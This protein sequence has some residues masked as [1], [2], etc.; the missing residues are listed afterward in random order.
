MEIP[1]A[2]NQTTP[3]IS[4]LVDSLEERQEV[5]VRRGIFEFHVL[6]VRDPGPVLHL[7]GDVALLSVHRVDQLLL[8]LLRAVLELGRRPA[9]EDS[10]EVGV[11][12]QADPVLALVQDASVPLQ[13]TPGGGQ[14]S[15]RNMKDSRC[16]LLPAGLPDEVEL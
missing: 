10:D 14:G 13:E 8:R 5:D 3:H 6:K 4:R 11:A 12:V 1:P 16:A 7:E 2:T 15:V 9:G